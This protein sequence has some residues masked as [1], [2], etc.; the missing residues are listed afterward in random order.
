MPQKPVSNKSW[1]LLLSA[2]MKNNK[3][4]TKSDSMDS[5]IQKDTKA[6][7]EN[8]KIITNE[9]IEIKRRV[10]TLENKEG[11]ISEFIENVQEQMGLLQEKIDSIEA[12]INIL[13]K[14]IDMNTKKENESKEIIET[15]DNK[16]KAKQCKFDRKGFC[17]HRERCAYYHA[18]EICDKFV[19]IG[20]CSDLKC[21]KRHPHRCHS[22]IQSECRWGTDCR[23]LHREQMIEIII[24]ND[25]ANEYEGD[26]DDSEVNENVNDTDNDD[27]QTQKIENNECKECTYEDKCVPCIMLIAREELNT[28]YGSYEVEEL[29]IEAIMAKAKAFD[30]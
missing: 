5:N 7:I 9:V 25:K 20:V 22:F 21:R 18:S 19:V 4:H 17:Y 10:I 26:K 27:P 23:Y 30:L 12:S 24:K 13:D 15:S 8:Q 28:S 14:L 3:K 2:V 6:I 11:L 16:E 1:T 29:S